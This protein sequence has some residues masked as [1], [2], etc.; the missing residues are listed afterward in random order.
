MVIE[1]GAAGGHRRGSTE[2]SPEL[3]GVLNVTPDSFS[4][5]G[6]YLDPS[7]ALE[8]ARELLRDGASVLDVGGESSRPPGKTYGAGAERVPVDEEIRRVVPVIERLVGELGAK[9][10]IDTVKAEVAR[11]AIKAGARIVN[12]VSCGHDEALLD[13][14]GEHETTLVL[15]H[16]RGRGEVTPETTAYGDVV[17]DVAHELAL[18]IERANDRGV[19]PLRIWLDPGIGFA[20]TAR[21]SARLV[22]DLGPLRALCY[23]L[24][25]GP[26]RKSFIAEIA[27]NPDGTKPAPGEREAGTIAACIAAALAGAR[28]LRV[29]DVRA[30]RQ[31]LAVT[32]ALGFRA[33]E[34]PRGGA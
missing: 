32:Y 15:M 5:G 23:P 34:A 1:G 8:R 21:Q 29:H 25:V 12:D 9:V 11:A 3:W 13:V 20:K 10:S 17:A 26:S 19:A 27:P 33:Q 6:R 31:A 4:D 24:L 30:V 18:A 22:A 14:V 16:S 2:G 7:A 28:A